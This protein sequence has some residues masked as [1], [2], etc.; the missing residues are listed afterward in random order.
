MPPNIA[1]ATSRSV[2]L[3]LC[4]VLLW[5]AWA[6]AQRPVAGLGVLEACHRALDA[7]LQLAQH[8][9][10]LQSSRGALMVNQAAFEP[11]FSSSLNTS[12][13]LSPLTAEAQQASGLASLRNQ[14]VAAELG[15]SKLFRSGIQITPTLQ[16]SRSS[17]NQSQALGV[18]VATLTLQVVFPL[19]RNRGNPL[20]AVLEQAATLDEQATLHDVRHFISQVLSTTAS[21]Y[22]RY[23]GALETLQAYRDAEARAADMLESVKAMGS[24][25]LVPRVQVQDALSNLSSRAMVRIGQER[26]VAQ[27]R[28]ELALAMG[29]EA[30]ALTLD[31]RPIDPLPDVADG[32]PASVTVDRT[33]HFIALGLRNRAD[34]QAAQIRVE[35]QQAMLEGWRGQL[36]PQVDL[37]AGIS[38]AGAGLGRGVGSFLSPLGNPTGPSI[39]VGLQYRFPHE[40]LEARGALLQADA[41]LQQRLLRAE[42][43]QRQLVSEIVLGLQNLAS[44]TQQLAEAAAGVGAAQ[45]SHDGARERLKSG[46]GSVLDTLQTEDR[47]IT[48]LIGRIS[49]QVSLATAIA[50]LRYATGTF[51]SPESSKKGLSRDVFYKP[52]S[53]G[54]ETPP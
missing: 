43:V 1:S 41:S 16:F 26:V 49:A 30:A 51:V 12:R 35:Q 38:Y 34:L 4:A 24:V 32:A 17:D 23:Q 31:V 21:A 46:I 13:R 7:N 47:L 22:W 14:S 53:T 48:A 2:T 15:M 40:N 27:A 19:A 39:S 42:D 20:S 5:P 36:R 50:D 25:D 29:T 28:Q 9:Q 8:R 3:A 52:L 6:A 44:A 11:V 37:V 10:Q 45:A 33:E 18:N 54:L